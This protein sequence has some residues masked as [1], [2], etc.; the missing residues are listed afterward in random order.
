MTQK[1]KIEFP[2][3]IDVATAEKAF[4]N[5]QLLKG[6]FGESFGPIIDQISE[7]D[8]SKRSL[9]IHGE[10]NREGE[11]YYAEILVCMPN[12]VN[13]AI[14]KM[15]GK[16]PRA[17]INLEAVPKETSAFEERFEPTVIWRAKEFEPIKQFE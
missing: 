2:M 6:A 3:Y 4:D 9:G 16:E 5:P 17:T 12:F 11:I 1:N 10:L 15:L 14:R 8:E 7:I 13:K